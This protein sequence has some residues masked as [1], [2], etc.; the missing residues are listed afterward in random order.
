MKGSVSSLISLSHWLSVLPLP[1]HWVIVCN[2]PL[3]LSKVEVLVDGNPG[4][5]VSLTFNEQLQ[6]TAMIALKR[7]YPSLSS[8]FFNLPLIIRNVED[9]LKVIQFFGSEKLCIGNPD[10][11]LVN[12]WKKKCSSLHSYT[13]MLILFVFK[14]I[15][16]CHVCSL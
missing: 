9:V 10:P 4:V 2:E 7:I 8:I 16:T 12:M 5:T 1:L 15:F 13:G 14:N 6:W 3:T 11:G